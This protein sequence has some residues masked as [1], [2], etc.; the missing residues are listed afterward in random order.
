MN[1]M[2]TDLNSQF[3]IVKDAKEHLRDIGHELKTPITKGRFLIEK[4]DNATDRNNIKQIFID[5]DR[6]TNE[7]LEQEK[8]NFVKLNKSIFNADTLILESL[9][10]LFIN[11]ESKVSI[12]LDENFKI[13]ADFYYMSIVLKNLIDNAL[14]YSFEFPIEITVSDNRIYVKNKAEKLPHDL[15]FYIQPFSTINKKD[16]ENGHGLGLG[17]VNK[18]LQKHNFVLS[19]VYENNCN[20]S[21][22]TFSNCQQSVNN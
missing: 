12:K 8:L 22:I 10:K 7:L 19:Y 20:V 4:I 5:L 3:K 2:K 9:S 21:V 11:D 6:L 15:E 16:N 13:N 18:I 1:S 17:I 14:K